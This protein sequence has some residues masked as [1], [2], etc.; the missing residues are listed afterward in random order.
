MINFRLIRHLWLFQA[1]AEAGH[2]GRAAKRLGMSQPPLSEQIQALELALRI[3]LFDRGRHGAH[4]TPVGAAILPAVRNFAGQMERLE[5]AVR[6]AVAGRT[7]LL[8][9]GAISSAVVDDLPP[10]MEHLRATHP[11]LTVSIKEIDSVEAIPALEAREIDVAFARLEGEL[12]PNIR[13]LPVTEDRL[14]LVLPVGHPLAAMS[15]VPLA[16]LAHED[17]AMFS[18]LVS[19]VLFDHIVA[20]C[21]ANGLSPR[22]IHEVRTVNSQIAFVGCGQGIALVPASFEK[23]APRTVIFRP[24]AETVGVVTSALVWLANHQSPVVDGLV[25]FVRKARGDSAGSVGNSKPPAQ[26]S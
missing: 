20:A 8:T 11:Q 9:I 15:A 25:D 14:A 2:F 1:V 12:G 23:L 17:F 7:G 10:L 6:E 5:L 22:I 13:T 3:K 24:L 18:R 4:L 19:P 26:G 21:H 16:A